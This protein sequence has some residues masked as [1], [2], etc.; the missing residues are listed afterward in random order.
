MSQNEPLF[1]SAVAVRHFVPAVKSSLIQRSLHRT[2]RWGFEGG[3]PRSPCHHRGFRVWREC[4]VDCCGVWGA[5]C[6]SW[7]M[8]LH[9]LRL[10][11][12]FPSFLH[13][14]SLLWSFGCYA[15]F[16]FSFQR[17]VSHQWDLSL[18]FNNTFVSLVQNPGLLEL[19]RYLTR[20]SWPKFGLKC[21]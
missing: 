16:L 8:Q 2:L 3:A 20:K 18:Y 7:S 4:P 11:I 9:P 10:L 13:H 17:A 6:P 5:P 1:L 15:M 19:T 12:S 14:F 21:C